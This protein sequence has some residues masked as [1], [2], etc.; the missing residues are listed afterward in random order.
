MRKKLSTITLIVI[1]IAISVVSIVKLTGRGDRAT[2]MAALKER[3]ELRVAINVNLPGYFTFNGEAFGFQHD[4][5]EEYADAL[6]VDLKILPEKS[7][8]GAMALLDAGEVDMVATMP[9]YVDLQGRINLSSPAYNT[10]YVLLSSSRIDPAAALPSLDSLRG[11]VAGHSVVLTRAFTS[12]RIYERWL[13][14]VSSNSAISY[15]NTIDLFRSLDNGD[16]DFLVCDRMEAQLGRYL[17]PSA[18]QVYTFDESLS[19][20]VVVRGG[21]I[22]LQESFNG[23][24]SDFMATDRFAALHDIYYGDNVIGHYMDEVSEPISDGVVISKYDD[25]IKRASMKAGRDWRLVSAIAYNESR[26]KPDVVS[27]KGATGIMQ[28]M[29]SIARAFGRS[30]DQMTDAEINVETAL[31]LINKIESSLKFAPGTSEYDRLCIV[32][33][34]YNGGI[35]HVLDARRLAVKYGENPDLWSSVSKYLVKK[36]EAEY[37]NDEAVTS[38]RFLGSDETCSFVSKVMQRFAHY[39][40]KVK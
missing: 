20:A 7:T 35:G 17:Y 38:G 4:V 2:D 23:W 10:G 34:C 36:S 6:G 30:A 29:P 9:G 39:R 3:G 12:T 28:V 40:S 25:I 5:L 26:F 14:R 15:D 32:L 21:D 22:V 27:P 18:R 19:A 8:E 33:A 16:I 37:Y 11:I 13:D 24:V 31:K 1:L